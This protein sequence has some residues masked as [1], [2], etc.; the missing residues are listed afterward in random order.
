MFLRSGRRREHEA[1]A[2]WV[3]ELR[4]AMGA[5]TGPDELEAGLPQVDEPLEEPL[6]AAD[7]SQSVRLLRARLVSCGQNRFWTE[8]EPNN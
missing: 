6:C 2:A 5:L 7:L 8:L 1:G 4:Q 3:Q